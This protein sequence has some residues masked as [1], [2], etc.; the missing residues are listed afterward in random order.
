MDK[1]IKMLKRHEGA[2]THVYLCSENRHT[3]GV[4]RNVDPRGGLGISEDEIDYLLSND[5]LR[6]IKELTRALPW[7]NRLDDVRR[8]ALIDLCFNLGLTRLLRF[9]K[10]LA[11]MEASEWLTAKIELLD[12]RWAKQVGNRSA[13]IAEMI[14]T[15]E[16]Q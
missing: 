13:E 16:Y 9:K 10:A 14:R 2:E 8:D 6:C 12:S 4:G 1:L 3:I 7:F 15:G 5:V 11:A